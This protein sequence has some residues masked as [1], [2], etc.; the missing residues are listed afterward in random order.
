LAGTVAADGNTL[1]LTI[2]PD[3]GL[4]YDTWSGGVAPGTDVN[5]NGYTALA[6]FALGASAPGAPFAVPVQGLTNSG[7]TNFLTLTAVVRTNGTGLTVTGQSA[8]NLAAPD[9]WTAAG[10]TFTPTGATDV[11]DGCE[12]RIYRTP[13]DG[14][15]KFLRLRMELAP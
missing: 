6:E 9:A 1:V 3:T 15:R 10:V 7:G 2:A 14:A 12:Q 4:D 11:P 5:G 8:A 13:A